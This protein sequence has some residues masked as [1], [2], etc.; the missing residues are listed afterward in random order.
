MRNVRL[1]VCD[2]IRKLE[3]QCTRNVHFKSLSGNKHKI[4]FFTNGN[5]FSSIFKED[6]KFK[7]VL[8]VVPLNTLKMCIISKTLCLFENVPVIG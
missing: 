8:G 7:R 1:E 3:V 5:D 6:Y 4:Y 2:C